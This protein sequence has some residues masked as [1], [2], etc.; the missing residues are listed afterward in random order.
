MFQNIEWLDMQ[1]LHHHVKTT[2]GVLI[3][4]ITCLATIE[5]LLIIITFCV[6]PTLRTPSNKIIISITVADFFTGIVIC[7]IFAVI[8]LQEES[9]NCDFA[10]GRSFPMHTFLIASVL[11]VVFL[12]VDRALRIRKLN[13][14]KLPEKVLNGVFVLIWLFSLASCA[15]PF[16]DVGGPTYGILVGIGAAATVLSICVSYL[17]LIIFLRRHRTQDTSEQIQNSLVEREKKAAKTV[18]IIITCY[19]ATLL[20]GAFGAVLYAGMV[21][22]VDRVGE[23]VGIVCVFLNL[24]NSVINPVIYVCRMS[25]LRNSLKRLVCQMLPFTADS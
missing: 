13:D 17:C 1:H 12:A 19:V 25:K 11:S 9:V 20:P 24:C 18:A 7:P 16:I 10:I 23:S 3:I 22:G 2:F 21:I 5:N 8:L 6:N 14:Y 4:L 15:G